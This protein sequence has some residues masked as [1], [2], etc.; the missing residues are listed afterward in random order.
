MVLGDPYVGLFD[1]QRDHDTGLYRSL[2]R[3][4]T[5]GLLEGERLRERTRH[6]QALLK[7]TEGG[8]TLRLL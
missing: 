8:V 7:T 1:P 6:T 4:S 3:S 5:Q 2:Y